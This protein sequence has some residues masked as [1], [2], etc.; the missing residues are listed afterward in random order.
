MTFKEI[1]NMIASF[2]VS[3]TYHEWDCESAD[4]PPLPWVAFR[5]PN[6]SDFYADNKNYQ[7]VTALEI[8]LCTENKDFETEQGIED[9]LTSKGLTYNKIEDYIESE[10][11]FDVKY[12]LEVV[13]T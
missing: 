10:R 5:Y 12:E 4:V 8:E 3:Y 1:N 9:I 7:R 6:I 13:I 11:M 2:G